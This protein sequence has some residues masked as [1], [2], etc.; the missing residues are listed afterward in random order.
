MDH[1][2]VLS[3]ASVPGVVCLS[4][5]IYTRTY[6]MG[7]DQYMYAAAKAGSWNEH[8]TPREL[9]YRR[10]HPNLQGWMEQLWLQKNPDID[11]NNRD[12]L[13]NGVEL[14]LTWDDL[15]ELEQAIKLKQL[16]ET[17]GFFFGN[18]ADE[19]YY[20]EDLEFVKLAKTE[21]FCGLRVFYNSSW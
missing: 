9:G 4:V 14:E 5:L 16:P 18:A 17:K 15:E 11:P 8:P 10:K 12:V 3:F 1:T 13:F 21:I 6:E 20:T 2:V 7:L 19:H